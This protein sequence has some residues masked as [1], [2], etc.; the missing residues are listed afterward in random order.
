[1]RSDGAMSVCLYGRPSPQGTF[2]DDGDSYTLHFF[3]GHIT[4][5]HE[6][7][8]DQAGKVTCASMHV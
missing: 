1:M 4:V 6:C 3:G 7:P 2:A 5:D 8:T